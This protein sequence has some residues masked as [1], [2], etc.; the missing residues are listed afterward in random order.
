M[1]QQ[2]NAVQGPAPSQAAPFIA[3]SQSAFH[4]PAFSQSPGS[5]P[6]FPSEE[7]LRQLFG[8]RNG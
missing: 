5:A 2:Y 7:R 6:V 3:P 4:Q 1:L 8:S